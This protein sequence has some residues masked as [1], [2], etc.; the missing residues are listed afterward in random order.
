MFCLVFL[1]ISDHQLYYPQH[2]FKGL[3]LKKIFKKIDRFKQ[4]RSGAWSVDVALWESFL[5]ATLDTFLLFKRVHSTLV[6][7]Q[8]FSPT[9]LAVSLH[10]MKINAGFSFADPFLGSCV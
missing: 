3:Y 4:L 6:N 8:V 2:V 7:A 1:E 10:K 5:K 9:W